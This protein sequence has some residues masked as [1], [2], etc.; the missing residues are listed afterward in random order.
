MK[1]SEKADIKDD[2]EAFLK[3]PVGERT[4]TMINKEENKNK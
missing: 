4:S 2:N 1:K 3:G